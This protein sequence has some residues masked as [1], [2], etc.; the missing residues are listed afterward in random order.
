MK[1][2]DSSSGFSVGAL[3]S[4]AC[5][6]RDVLLEGLA[7]VGTWFQGAFADPA[8]PGEELNAL[9]AA[10]DLGTGCVSY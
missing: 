4:G 8:S 3:E 6:T 10:R 9:N 2:S 7:Q 1:S 5:L